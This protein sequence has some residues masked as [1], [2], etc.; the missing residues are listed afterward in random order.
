MYIDT[1]AHIYLDQFK[2]DQDAIIERCLSAKVT[3]VLLPNIDIDT[4]EDV[5]GLVKQFPGICHP[6]VGLHPCSVTKEYQQQLTELKEHLSKASVIAVGEI[7]IDLYWDTSLHKEQEA[8]FR[9]Q[10]EW[11]KEHHLPIV[12]H[13][14]NSL[15]HTIRIVQE[16]QDGSLSGVFHCFG[17]SK[18]EAQ[19][20]IDVGFHL[21]IG[22]VATF[23]KTQALRDL[24]KDIPLNSLLLETDAPY[25]TPAPFRG[26]RNESSYIPYI[27]QVI[28]DA[29]GI[30]IEEVGRVTSESAK[31]LF[32]LL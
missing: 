16:M 3:K 12:I 31:V 6:M 29:K 7:G 2:N 18:K 14:R 15:E 25:L 19:Q 13:S 10:I 24:I 26:K 8:A 30:E 22:G 28:A 23:K 4:M 11:S 20:I 9:L 21:G 5:F 27:A 32:G 17:E 1:H